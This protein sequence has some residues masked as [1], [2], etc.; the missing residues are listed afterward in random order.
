MQLTKSKFVLAARG[1]QLNMERSPRALAL[2]G[3]L[4]TFKVVNVTKGSFILE[5]GFS[6]A[7]SASVAGVVVLRQ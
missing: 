2:I 7:M 6:C 1:V 4:L 3:V 5:G